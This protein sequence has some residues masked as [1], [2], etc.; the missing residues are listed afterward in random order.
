MRAAKRMAVSRTGK[1]EFP[2]ERVWEIVGDFS[3]MAKWNENIVE[4]EIEERSGAIIRKMKNRVGAF[5]EERLLAHNPKEMTIVYGMDTPPTARIERYTAYLQ[6]VTIDQSASLLLWTSS[7]E[8]RFKKVIAAEFGRLM[9]KAMTSL[10]HYLET[11]NKRS[12]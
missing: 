1:F 8:T 11:G 5:M 10:N 6:V 7:C 4:T 12:G 3:A 9:V 2:A